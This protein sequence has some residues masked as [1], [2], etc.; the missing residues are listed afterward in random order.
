MPTFSEL[1]ERFEDRHIGPRSADLAV[2]LDAIG[3]ASADELIG[4]TVPDSILDNRPKPMEALLAMSLR[5]LSASEQKR[6][7]CPRPRRDCHPGSR[8]PAA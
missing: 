4:Q 5:Q 2:M 1:T 8:E 3:V 7:A 6:L